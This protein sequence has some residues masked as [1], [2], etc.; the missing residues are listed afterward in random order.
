MVNSSI[1]NHKKFQKPDENS[2]QEFVDPEL[3]EEYSCVV[4]QRNNEEIL[5]LS[6]ILH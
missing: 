5:G 2:N 4:F 6:W 1:L 3:T